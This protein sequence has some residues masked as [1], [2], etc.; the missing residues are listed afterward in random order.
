MLVWKNKWMNASQ[1]LVHGHWATFTKVTLAWLAPSIL[2]FLFLLNSFSPLLALLLRGREVPQSNHHLPVVC[3]S[4]TTAVFAHL[5]LPLFTGWLKLVTVPRCS[6]WQI[7]SFPT[8]FLGSLMWR[9]L[10]TD[11]VPLGC[12]IISVLLSIPD[13]A[14]FQEIAGAGRALAEQVTFRWSSDNL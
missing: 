1:H 10:M 14:T 11:V 3:A 6:T 2:V 13:P 12:V 4:V 8:W 7:T 5:L 9:T